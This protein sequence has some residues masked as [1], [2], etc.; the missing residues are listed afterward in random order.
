M[1]CC[2][3]P[4][5]MSPPCNPSLADVA[6]FLASS[7]LTLDSM[8]NEHYLPQIPD[9]ENWVPYPQWISLDKINKRLKGKGDCFYLYAKDLINDLHQLYLNAEV[10]DQA[11]SLQ[12]CTFCPPKLTVSYVQRYNTPGNGQI[13]NTGQA[14][15][16]TLR[17]K[18]CIHLQSSCSISVCHM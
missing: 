4:P 15:M 16:S 17:R 12:D 14:P 9:Y 10:Q 18:P 6:S 13:G 8:Q 7:P 2:M 5:D 11:C 1:A 3:R